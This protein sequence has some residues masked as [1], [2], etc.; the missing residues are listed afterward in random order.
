M[1][2]YFAFARSAFHSQL[3]YRNEVWANIFGKLVQVFARVAIWQAAYAGVSATMVDGVS[4]QQMVTYALLGGA[5]MGATRPE[6]IIGEIGRSLKTGDVVVW[7]LKP[8]SYPLYLFAN[9]CGSFG[10]RLMTQVIPTVAFTAL[11]YGMLAPASLFHALM[12]IAF[13]ALSF[14]LLF[15]MSA[16]FGLIAFWL[17]TSFSL[18]WI[19]GALLQLFS[20]LLVPFWFFPEPLA[21]A[22][23]HLP[24][25]WVVYYPNA[26]YLGRL[27]TADVWLNLGLGLGWTVL[28]LVGVLWLWRLASGRITVQG[29]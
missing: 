19:L 22:A 16:L 1:S 28:F 8:L 3:A 27:S 23:R 11:F 13:W 17:M 29:G 5:V 7:L 18:D 15:L 14:T 4:L 12:F 10:Y 26:V 21:T 20:G 24:F 9:E 25:A 2:A 6:R